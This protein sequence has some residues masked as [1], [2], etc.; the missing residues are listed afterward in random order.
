MHGSQKLKKYLNEKKIPEFEKD[1]ILLL[2]QGNEVLWV[3]G[4]GISEKIK[5][6]DT[7]THVIYIEERPENCEKY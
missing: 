6:T 4:Y 2:C 1:K 3:S 5:V 7:P